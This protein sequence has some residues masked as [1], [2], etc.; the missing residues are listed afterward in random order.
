MTSA[1][2]R[3]ATLVPA[4]RARH[5]VIAVFMQAINAV[6]YSWSVFRGPLA[7]L[8]HWSKAQTIAPYRYS[9]LAVAIGTIIGGL[10]QDRKGPRLVASVGGLMLFV[11]SLISA[12]SGDNLTML[13][14][15]YG[16]IGGLGGGF[17][18][19]TPIANLVRW[20]PDKRGTMVGL[21]VMGS[22]LSPL[23]WSPLIEWIVGKDA[24][25]LHT[26]LPLAFIVMACIFIVGLVLPAQ[27]MRVPPKGW[28][29]EGWTQPVHRAAVRDVSTGQML[30]TWQFY[31]LWLAF[32]LGVGVGLTA[33]GQASPLIQEISRSSTMPFSAGIAVG[34]M[35]IFNAG[36]R[37]TWGTVSDRIGRKT[38]LFSMSCV[39]IVACLGLLRNASGFWG[40]VAGLCLAAFAYGG[41]L[42]VMPAFSADYYGQSNV[43]GNYGFLFLAWGVCGFLIPG[44]FEAILDRARE[45]GNLAAGYREVYWDLAMLAIAVAVLAIIVRPPRAAAAAKIG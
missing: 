24:A 23:F 45:A 4:S 19:V 6:V 15:G 5:A 7:E 33:I 9:L 1:A 8:H 28:K 2:A 29:P 31:A 37:L 3:T 21:A 38:A 27:F 30:S 22:G 14:I 42:A 39:S 40:V 32:V 10:W 17:V 44:Y 36:G 18:Y 34:I 25:Q 43:G 12:F 35:G 20:F 41:F 16:L 13:V 11:G 26:T